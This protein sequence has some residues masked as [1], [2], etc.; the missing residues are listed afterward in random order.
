MQHPVRVG[1]AHVGAALGFPRQV[2]AQDAQRVF[3]V[4][5]GAQTLPAVHVGAG[6]AFKDHDLAGAGDGQCWEDKIFTDARDEVEVHCREFLARLHAVD[7]GQCQ[8][9]LRSGI[10]AAFGIAFE[11]SCNIPLACG[12]NHQVGGF[13]V[14]FKVGH[15]GFLKDQGAAAGLKDFHERR[16]FD[17]LVN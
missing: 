8:G 9:A 3:Q 4:R 11:E 10:V 7:V 5:F 14:A 12:D 17:S 13:C 15:A 6:Q 1:E 2:G 16:E